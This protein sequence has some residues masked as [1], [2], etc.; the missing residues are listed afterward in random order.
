MKIEIITEKLLTLLTKAGRL[1]SKHLS[2]P[3]LSHV[4]LSAK[5]GTLTVRATNLEMGIECFAPAKVGREGE[6]TTPSAVL[7]SFIS[8][9]RNVK[10]ITMELKDGKLLVGGGNT[11]SLMHTGSPDDFPTVPKAEGEGSSADPRALLAGFKAVH[12]AGAVGNLKPELGSVYLYQENGSL[13]FAA[14]DSFR[15]AE[16]QIPVKKEL[17]TEGILVPIRNAAEFMRLLEEE[18]DEVTFRVGGGKLTLET[19]S[20]FVTSRLVEGTFPDYKQII[21]K[22]Q[23]TEAVM[24]KEDLATGLKVTSL[25]SDRFN[26]LNIQVLPG[27]KTLEL[28][29]RSAEAGEGSF[30]VSA[31]LSGRDIKANFNHRYIQDCLA[32]IQGDSISMSWSGE[33]KPLLISGVGDRSFRYIVMPMNR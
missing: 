12:Y 16:K 19:P 7:L 29:A 25:F 20:M 27:E 32:A 1:T 9:L 13:F 24:L 17:I 11:K 21:P 15:L 3:I 10:S 18:K 8:N 4:L 23:T 26:Q 30:A 5:S 28:A 6:L 31:A 33:N 2:L 14:T 22:E